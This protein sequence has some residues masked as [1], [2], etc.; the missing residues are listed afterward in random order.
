M[1]RQSKKAFSFNIIDAMLIIIA[2]LCICATIFFFTD[3]D[4]TN[5]KDDEKVILEYTVEF[6]PIREEFRNFLEI[7]DPI[8][9]SSNMKEAG[10]IVNVI[11]Y[12]H[13][14]YGT[15]DETGETVSSKYPGKINMTLTVR[16]EAVKTDT[17]Y[18]I[19]GYELLIGNSIN[20][21]TPDFTGTGVCT[22]I[23][24]SDASK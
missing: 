13:L 24:V 9:E 18:S 10:E 7:G 11:Y 20:I 8:T 23:T 4:I 12:D 16:A 3:A 14:Y 2:L 22:S 21:R 17:G 15:N 6:N 1:N 5:S 19:N